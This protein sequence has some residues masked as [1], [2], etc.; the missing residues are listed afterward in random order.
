LKQFYKEELDIGLSSI[1]EKGGKNGKKMKQLKPSDN[2]E[3][4]V[5]SNYEEN[6][7][8]RAFCKIKQYDLLN[9]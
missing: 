6:I 8:Y 4:S 7:F 2:K 9:S 1:S 3:K 5:I